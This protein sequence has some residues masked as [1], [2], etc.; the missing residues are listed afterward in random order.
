MSKI[1]FLGDLFFDYDNIPIDIEEISNYIK[2][3][4]YKCIFFCM[5]NAYMFMRINKIWFT[6]L[7]FSYFKIFRIISTSY[8]PYH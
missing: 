8:Y 5:T 4:N 7:I 2:R 1:L 3:N 6:I